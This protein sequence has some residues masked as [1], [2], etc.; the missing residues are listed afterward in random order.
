MTLFRAEC[1][2]EQ[3]AVQQCEELARS[4]AGHPIA[5]DVALLGSR[6]STL[7]SLALRGLGQLRQAVTAATAA[8]VR[9]EAHAAVAPG[10]EATP[11]RVQA[12]LALIS[13]LAESDRVP[14]AWTE[15]QLLEDL[16]TED[17]D[18]QIAGKTYWAIGNV[19]FLRDRVQE[20]QRYHERAARHLSPATDLDLWAKFNSDS[21]Q[22][23][24]TA[25]IVDQQT[26]ECIERAELAAEI[27]GGNPPE[28]LE[29]VMTRA[30]WHHQMGETDE[31]VELLRPVCA[32]FG[33]L[34]SHTAGKASFL[35]GRC[36]Q[37]QGQAR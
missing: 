35:L 12:Q 17:I 33:M 32:Q 13:A 23:R 25:Q 9:A 7:L 18:G 20:G 2:R 28:R 30:Q 16:L 11:L 14:E 6:A 3:G 24:L 5:A 22:M 4:L 21:A 1:L 31:A 10:P 34:A 36:L 26:L 29:L 19:A 8:A 27:V 37:E 15:C